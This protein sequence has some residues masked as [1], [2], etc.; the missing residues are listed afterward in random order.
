MNYIES[1]IAN[2]SCLES[3]PEEEQLRLFK[4]YKENGNSES[5]DILTMSLYRL[6]QHIAGEFSCNTEDLCSQGMI[7]LNNALESFNPE[8]GTKFSTYAATCIKNS[9][10]GSLKSCNLVNLSSS[11]KK[12]LKDIRD[13]MDDYYLDNS[14]EEASI[15][16]II[17]HFGGKFDYDYVVE[18]LNFNP[19]TVSLDRP[20][21][22]EDGDCFHE[23]IA[24]E[25]ETS[26][27]DYVEK[28]ELK[29]SI[30]RSLD[31]LDSEQRMAIELK[32][33]LNGR[34]TETL[35]ELANRLD[36][37]KSYVEKLI[38][39]GLNKLKEMKIR[40]N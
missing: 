24:D 30:N 5:R 29:D 31:S 17:E 12:D 2:K 28:N 26:P 6:V 37:D 25:S 39:D 21:G 4:D 1:H 27:S 15:D 22:D 8:S 38:E 16:E 33:G 7:G 35:D 10:I 40:R 13:F 9:I 32:F 23:I 19:N 20:I 14:G 34:P 3:L 18:L 11:M 36:C